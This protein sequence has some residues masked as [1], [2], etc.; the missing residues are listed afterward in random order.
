MSNLVRRL[1]NGTWLASTDGESGDLRS[2]ALKNFN[3]TNNKLSVFEI[4]GSVY[5][6]ERMAIAVAARSQRLEQVDYIEFEH[7]IA[8]ELEI[9]LDETAGDT[10][11]QEANKLHRDLQIGSTKKLCALAE[12]IYRTSKPQRVSKPNVAKLLLNA[13]DDGLIDLKCLEV[14]M[15]KELEEFRSRHA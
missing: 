13:I 1:K 5:S 11:D 10:P 12:A 4:D 6:A 2:D 15:R 7:Q 8:F 9:L 3:T 14:S